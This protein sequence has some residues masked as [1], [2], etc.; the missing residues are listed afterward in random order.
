MNGARAAGCRTGLSP[1]ILHFLLD[2]GSP[3]GL[4]SPAP[5]ARDRPARPGAPWRRRVDSSTRRSLSTPATGEHGAESSQRQP[6]LFRSV[7]P[8]PLAKSRAGAIGYLV[9]GRQNRRRGHP[10]NRSDEEAQD[11]RHS[12]Y[13]A[14]RQGSAL[15]PSF[16]WNRHSMRT[17]RPSGRPPS[18]GR[19]ARKGVDRPPADMRRSLRG[20]PRT[21][22][23]RFRASGPH[24]PLS[25]FRGRGAGG[26]G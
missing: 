4:R 24:A 13:Q 26:E 7:A 2:D 9:A 20:P 25:R 11:D 3:S 8:P 17:T 6:A 10:P 5:I 14:R 1:R 21:T 15:L 19:L 16:S 18:R 12:P 22:V 23:L